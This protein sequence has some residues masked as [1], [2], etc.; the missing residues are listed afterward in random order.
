MSAVLLRILVYSILFSSLSSLSNHNPRPRHLYTLLFQ[1]SKQGVHSSRSTPEVSRSRATHA[2][3]FSS[4]CYFILTLG[5]FTASLFSYSSRLW[6]MSALLPR[7]LFLVPPRMCIIRSL[8]SS[9]LHATLLFPVRKECVRQAQLHSRS[10][11]VPSYSC[12][13]RF[14][15]VLS[16]HVVLFC[17]D[18]LRAGYVPAASGPLIEIILDFIS[19]NATA[20][21][22]S[23]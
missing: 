1:D 9:P 11:R 15:S 19:A 20:F 6:L 10:T 16:S 22:A 5:C 13:Q 7:I 4:R 8:V 17:S 3:S 14:E 2:I 21:A 12:H 23:R 18:P